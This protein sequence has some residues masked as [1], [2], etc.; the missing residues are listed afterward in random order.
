M[1]DVVHAAVACG[2]YVVIDFHSHRANEHLKE[3]TEFFEQVARDYGEYPKL[4]AGV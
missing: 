3:A 4:G 1:R 2:L